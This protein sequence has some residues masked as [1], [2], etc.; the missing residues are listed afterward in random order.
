MAIT[1]PLL[2]VTEKTASTLPLVD[3]FKAVQ[4]WDTDAR[5]FSD[6]QAKEDGLPV[7]EGQAL[8]RTGWSRKVE[9][10]RL[11]VLASQRPDIKLDPVK[12]AEAMTGKLNNETPSRLAPSAP[13]IGG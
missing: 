8:M 7:W 13:K 6:E 3:E 4:V 9:P 12:L 10:V 5:T 11:R 2:W 1:I